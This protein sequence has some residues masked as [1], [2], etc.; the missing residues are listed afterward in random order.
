MPIMLAIIKNTENNKFGEDVEK[1]EPT[2]PL[3]EM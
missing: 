2:T 3:A 1:L